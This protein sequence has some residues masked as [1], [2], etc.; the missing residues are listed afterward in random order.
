[1]HHIN[2]ARESNDVILPRASWIATG[3]AR[4]GR[5][6]DRTSQGVDISDHSCDCGSF[7]IQNVGSRSHKAALR[8]KADRSVIALSHVCEQKE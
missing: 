7:A 5:R 3:Q 1:M 8:T 6:G 4:A 2:V